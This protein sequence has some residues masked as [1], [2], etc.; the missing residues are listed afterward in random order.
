VLYPPALHHPLT[1]LRRERTDR[2]LLGAAIQLMWRPYQR[3]VVSLAFAPPL[4]AAD[5]LRREGDPAR[6]TGAIRDAARHLLANWPTEW[7]T[8]VAGRG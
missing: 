7:R 5:L 1:R 8:V 3:N 4:C 6:V 2:E